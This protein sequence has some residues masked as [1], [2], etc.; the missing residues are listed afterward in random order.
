MALFRRGRP[1][2]PPPAAHG[3]SYTHALA[4]QQPNIAPVLNTP[5]LP[6]MPT[7]QPPTVYE[8]SLDCP[9]CSETFTLTIPR[10]VKVLDYLFGYN[11]ICQNCGVPIAANIRTEEVEHEHEPSHAQ[12]RP[13]RE[14]RR[15]GRPPRV[16]L[17]QKR[18]AVPSAMAGESYEEYD[19]EE[20]EP[21]VGEDGIP[22][23]AYKTPKPKATKKQ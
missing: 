23:Y 13:I 17:P 1:I 8:F 19:A 12:E 7:P 15:V 20:V 5:A 11:I 4:A 3:A 2:E 10:G 18:P 14:V 16:H 6:P 21:Y 9:N 22:D